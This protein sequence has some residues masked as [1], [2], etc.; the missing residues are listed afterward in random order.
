MNAFNNQG[1]V[2]N[3]DV[4]T[5]AS[6]PNLLSGGS[7]GATL[8]QSEVGLEVFGPTLAGA[9]TSADIQLDFGGGAP[10]IP[11]GVTSG[12]LRLRTATM[13][14]DWDRT[15]LIAG[16]D[17]L[18][19]S[20]QS[21]TSFASLIVP[22]L[23]Y[24]GNLWSWVPQIR[25]EHRLNFTEGSG[26]TLQGGVLDPLTG[27]LPGLGFYRG[28]SAGEN[29]RAPGVGTRAAWS[30]RVFGR[31]L[32]LGVAGYYSRQN[33]GYGRELNGWVGSSD[34]QIPFTSWLTLTGEF[35]RGSAIGG[36]GGGIGR[37]VLFSGAPNNPATSVIPLNAIGG[38]TQVKVAPA[39]KLEFNAAAGQDNPYAKDLRFFPNPQSY[40][41]PFISR[42][43]A[44]FVNFVYRPRSDLLVSA[45]F[46][47]LRTFEI[48]GDSNTA[49]HVNL[50]MGFLF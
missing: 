19:I 48:N 30:Q 11:N 10:V 43:R 20:P 17:G 24:S 39:P 28:A 16:Q 1:V 6:Y 31:A 12:L 25:A 14:M 5:L 36:L 22:A 18:F 8:R 42:N 3:I 34:W 32:I 50:A 2:D 40:L 45:E 26:L 4:P 35:Y 21:P 47:H 37:S 29:S 44:E 38:W 7:T 15:S 9:R 27:E 46:R 23:A 41:N 49:N 33:W 13:R